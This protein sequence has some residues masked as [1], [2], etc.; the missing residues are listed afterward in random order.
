MKFMAAFAFNTSRSIHRDQY[1]KMGAESGRLGYPTSD[2]VP[3]PDGF[4]RVNN[5]EHGF[6]YWSPRTLRT[7][8]FRPVRI[9]PGGR[10][11][12]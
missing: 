3:A 7:R 4:G 8:R 6:I 12:A 10:S 1:M 9:Q 5:F 2:E 11:I